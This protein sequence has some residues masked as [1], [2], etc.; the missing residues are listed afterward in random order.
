MAERDGEIAGWI[1]G[2]RLP[3]AP[4]QFFVWQVA[5]HT[6]ARGI[7]LGGR[8][9]DELMARPSTSGVTTLN[10]TITEA[11]AASW[12]LFASFARRHDAPFVRRPIFDRDAHFAGAHETE[13]LVSIG[14]FAGAVSPF[15][16]EQS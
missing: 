1:S 12:R 11:N 6:A 3:T 5:V 14:P 8:M 10:T 7:G 16:Q 15:R 13:H 4:N 9:L 2:Y